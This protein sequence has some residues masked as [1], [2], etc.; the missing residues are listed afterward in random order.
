M[1]STALAAPLALL[2]F[3][4]AVQAQGPGSHAEATAFGTIRVDAAYAARDTCQ[5]ILSAGRGTPSGAAVAAF[6]VPVIVVV[7]RDP[8]G[9]GGS[10]VVRRVFQVPGRFQVD[11]VEIFFVTPTGRLLKHEKVSVQPY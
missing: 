9:C 10:R 7:G 5:T 4:S 6:N 8:A 2:P 3:V 11:L 1:R